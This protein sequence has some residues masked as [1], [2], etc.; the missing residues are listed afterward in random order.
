[1]QNV[2]VPDDMQVGTVHPTRTFGDI[3]VVNYNG[4]K[5]VKVRFLNTGYE[6]VVSTSQVRR[7]LIRDLWFV[8]EDMKSGTIHPTKMNGDLEIIK[9]TD[10]DNIRIKFIKS[11]YERNTKAC[12]IRRGIVGDPT[13]IP[14]D[15]IAGT[16]YK[17]N[18]FG[19]YEVVE[20]ISSM[21]VKIRFVDTGYEKISRSS[22]VRKGDIRD[23]LMPIVKGVGYLGD[24]PYKSK[25]DNKTLPEYDCWKTMLE[26][27]YPSND[28]Y[29][30]H[31]KTYSDCN[32]CEE[33]HDFQNF[34][35]WYHKTHPKDGNVWQLD[36][37]K[38]AKNGVKLYSP[39]TCCWLTPQENTEITHAKSFRLISPDGEIV[40]GVNRTKFA[41]ENGLHQSSLNRL[42]RGEQSVHKGWRVATNND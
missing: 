21:E 17:S 2:K 5:E 29:K 3:E 37:D 14:D 16:R 23:N 24:G 19:Y 11:G 22:N 20:Y 41:K 9:Y 18:G 7:G 38:L 13:F 28:F 35:E 33:W 1:M 25:K 6:T 15:M 8:P 4:S 40:E 27:C 31:Y 10:S 36:K 39:D 30:N 12:D 26:R 42:I 34:A 32:V